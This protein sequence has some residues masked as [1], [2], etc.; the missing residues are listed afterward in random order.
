M[1]SRRFLAMADRLPAYGGVLSA[2]VTGER[3]LVSDPGEPA[4][5]GGGAV[6][7][8]R[9]VLGG[10]AEFAAAPGIPAVISFG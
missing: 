4:A 5:A 8:T 6:P 2:I 3:Y 9:A 1:P 10:S 7:G